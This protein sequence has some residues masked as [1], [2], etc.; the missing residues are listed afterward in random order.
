MT[1]RRMPFRSVP[2]AVW[3][4]TYGERDAYGNRTVSY[5]EEADIVTTCCYAPGYSQPNTSDD[6]QQG[7]PHGDRVGVLFFLPKEFDAD[8]RGARI[9]CY[10]PDD[11]TI[12]SKLFDIVGEPTSYM[13]ANT[14][15]DYSWCVEAVAHDG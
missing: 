8:L 14:P 12:H 9:A 5:G 3:L 15:G 6:I 7:R 1:A 10:P 13:R 2:C 4:P 11:Q